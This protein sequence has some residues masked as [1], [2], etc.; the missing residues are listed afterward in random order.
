MNV[1]EFRPCPACRGYDLERR[2]CHVCDGR[3]VVDVEAQQKER[4]EMVKLLRAAG[5]EVRD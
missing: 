1:P 5:I 3:G 4:A 2:W